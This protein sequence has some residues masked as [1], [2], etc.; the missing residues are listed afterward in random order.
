MKRQ[1][2]PLVL[3]C[4][5]MVLFFTITSCSVLK[6]NQISVDSPAIETVTTDSDK[7]HLTERSNVDM[8]DMMKSYTPTKSSD[9]NASSLTKQSFTAKDGSTLNY[10]LYIPANAVDEMPIVIYLHGGSGKGDDLDLL[11]RNDGFPKYLQ[12]GLLG[13]V[14]AYIV[15]PQVPTAKKGWMDVKNAVRDLVYDCCNTYGTDIN[16]VSLTGHSMGGTGTW[17]LALAFPTLFSCV[18]PLSGSIATNDTNITALSNM[19]IRAFVGSADKIVP[20]DSSTQFITAL[21]KCNTNAQITV[22]EG[23]DHFS[24]PGL[25]YLDKGIDVLHWMISQAKR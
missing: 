16:R 17:S 11:M 24:I 2:M 9:S 23:A 21:S 14:Q 8:K 13:E 20:P 22:F 1:L 3:V 25:V 19:G 5:L 15:I 18:V 7:S 6:D 4:V 12:E 10:W